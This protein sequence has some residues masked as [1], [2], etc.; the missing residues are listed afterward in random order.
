MRTSK[1][2]ST[3]STALQICCHN[4]SDNM[5]VFR[6]VTVQGP[7]LTVKTPSSTHS[8]VNTFKCTSTAW[9]KVFYA[10]CL[11]WYMVEWVSNN[12]KAHTH[13]HACS[14]HVGCHFQWAHSSQHTYKH[15]H[16]LVG[17]KA[18]NVSL[19][20]CNK[21]YY[22]GYFPDSAHLPQLSAVTTLWK[23]KFH[24]YA[25]L[26]YYFTHTECQITEFIHLMK[27]L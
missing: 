17:N 19:S 27:R 26:C 22:Y 6:P 3:E 24:T 25:I 15:K 20:T 21:H 12:C 1:W 13:S 7:F 5:Y 4:W 9:S 23:L 10:I 14:T 8:N 2:R 11:A 16:T 18:S